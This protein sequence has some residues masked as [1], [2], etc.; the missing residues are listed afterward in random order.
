MG[1]KSRKAGVISVLSC[2]VSCLMDTLRTRCDSTL[3]VVSYGK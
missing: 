1:R 2:F 3:G